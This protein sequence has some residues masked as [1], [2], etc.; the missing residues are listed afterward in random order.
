MASPGTKDPLNIYCLVFFSPSIIFI[1]RP[2][3]TTPPSLLIG[4][5]CLHAPLP[6]LA[7]SA[8]GLACASLVR[9]RR[10]DPDPSPSSS[11]SPRS[12]LDLPR[13]HRLVLVIAS[14]LPGSTRWHASPCA[15]RPLH[16]SAHRH[17][18]CQSARRRPRRRALILIVERSPLASTAPR[19]RPSSPMAGS[20]RM[21]ASSWSAPRARH[22]PRSSSS[23]SSPCLCSCSSSPSCLCSLCYM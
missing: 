2:R 9:A 22:P 17:P 12:D 19:A 11:P 16:R 1:L 4:S 5:N 3:A 13:P 6:S 18:L 8:G 10:S 21:H 14:F 23:I 20:T 7:V 15:R